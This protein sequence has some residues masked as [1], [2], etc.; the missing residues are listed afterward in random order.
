MENIEKWWFST[1]MLVLQRVS[2][3]D[4]FPPNTNPPKLAPWAAIRVPSQVAPATSSAW[5]RNRLCRFPQ[6]WVAGLP[7]KTATQHVRMWYGIMPSQVRAR[8]TLILVLSK[9]ESRKEFTDLSNITASNEITTKTIP[10]KRTAK[11][12]GIVPLTQATYSL[13]ELPYRAL[14]ALGLGATVFWMKP[15]R[16]GRCFSSR[17]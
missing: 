6:G 17:M 10:K 14:A 8:M 7:Q 13:N 12:H 4:P 15:R 5:S 1:A 3:I 2:Q 11:N 16:S 9:V